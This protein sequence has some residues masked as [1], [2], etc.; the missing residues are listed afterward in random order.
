MASGSFAGAT[1]GAFTRCRGP[2]S[3]M[4]PSCCSANRRRWSSAAISARGRARA[5]AAAGPDRPAEPQTSSRHR[6][7]SPRCRPDTRCR[8]T[9][10]RAGQARLAHAFHGSRQGVAGVRLAEG[11]AVLHGHPQHEPAAVRARPCRL[12]EE[13]ALTRGAHC[14]AAGF[15][16]GNC[17]D[18]S[19]FS[20]CLT[21]CSPAALESSRVLRLDRSTRAAGVRGGWRHEEAA[22]SRLLSNRGGQET[23]SGVSPPVESI[24]AGVPM[25]D[26]QHRKEHSQW[27]SL[28]RSLE[29]QSRWPAM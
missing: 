25:G 7:P 20:S 15:T 17:H 4:A 13:P 9:R 28:T 24:R 11:G 5:T 14:V 10:A 26:N 8:S 22:P 23:N 2:T 18:A 27:V 3:P 12:A 16:S 21:E 19:S 1:A 29:R 6:L